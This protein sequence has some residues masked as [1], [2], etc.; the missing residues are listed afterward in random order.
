MPRGATYVRWCLVPLEVRLDRLVLL[1]ELSHVG[2]KVLY[3]VGVG[4][5]VDA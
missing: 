2:H 4:E 3:D 5:R 1:V